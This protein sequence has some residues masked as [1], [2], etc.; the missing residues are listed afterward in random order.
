MYDLSDLERISKI[1]IKPSTDMVVKHMVK[2]GSVPPTSQDSRYE[3]KKRNAYAFEYDLEKTGT[4]GLL[5]NSDDTIAI[6]S[7]KHKIP[8]SVIPISVI[9]SYPQIPMFLLALAE[10]D[11][12]FRDKEN[13]HIYERDALD[14]IIG[15]KSN[16]KYDFLTGQGAIASFQAAVLSDNESVK[17]EGVIL[18]NPHGL[19]GTMTSYEYFSFS[20]QLRYILQ[21]FYVD[22]IALSQLGLLYYVAKMLSNKETV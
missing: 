20:T 5:F 1:V 2:L 8:N 4:K 13:K 7:T 17:Y 22:S 10:V 15:I 14:N 21:N 3:P 12:W 6:E 16:I 9:I 19:V 18:K 11:K